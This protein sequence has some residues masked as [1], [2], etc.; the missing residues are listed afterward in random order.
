MAMV[1]YLRKDKWQGSQEYP[2]MRGHCN[3]IYGGVSQEARL[4]RSWV[5]PAIVILDGDTL[6]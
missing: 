4:G 3:H 1:C 6:D 5:S 2:M